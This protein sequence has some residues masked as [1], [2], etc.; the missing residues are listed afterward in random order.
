MEVCFRFQMMV[1]WGIDPSHLGS[2]VEEVDQHQPA[3]LVFP[4]PTRYS[5]YQ[6]RPDNSSPSWP[7]R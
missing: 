3:Y 6:D 4:R 2:E 1:Y 7:G 5:G